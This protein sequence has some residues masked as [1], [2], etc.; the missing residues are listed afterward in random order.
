MGRLD[1][2][3]ERKIRIKRLRMRMRR[4]E[5]CNAKNGLKERRTWA[6]G[7]KRMDL[8]K[9]NVKD[10]GNGEEPVG[11]ISW[12]L[13][14]GGL[15]IRISFAFAWSPSKTSGTTSSVAAAFGI[16]KAREEH[17]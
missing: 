16:N 12:L 9:K 5:A 14:A 17:V 8:E 10:G 3:D 1:A 13:Y 15:G 6:A 7:T 2:K 4:T 11:R